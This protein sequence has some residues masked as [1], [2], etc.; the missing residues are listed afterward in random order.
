MPEQ[1]E[2]GGRFQA[3]ST[4][5]GRKNIL[6][7]SA[8]INPLGLSKKVRAA[9]EENID[10]IVH[11]PDVEVTQL[12]EK[13]GEFYGIDKNNI[14]VGNGAVE[15]LYILCR[16]L[17][18]KKVLLTAPTFS[19]YE[20]AAKSVGAQI[21]YF[22]LRERDNFAV[23][24]QDL[25][26]TIKNKNLL[27]LCN[28]NNPTGTLFTLQQLT[29]IIEHAEA[30]GCFVVVDES[31]MDFIGKSEEFSVNQLLK[32]S[33]NLFVLHSL[34]KF[35]ALP[36]LRLGFAA[37]PD[38]EVIRRMYLNKDPWNVN[39]LAQNA[40]A[41]ALADKTYQRRSRSYIKS[42]IDYLCEELSQFAKL[43]IYKPAVNFILINIH[44]TK[45]TSSQFCK[46]MLEENILLRDCSNYPGLSADFIR[47][48]VK[49]REEND[50]LLDALE[51]ILK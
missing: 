39:S 34:T 10:G 11:Y 49:K 12:R 15:L 19:E 50:A 43:K 46:K 20:R 40:G 1:F 35:F 5:S 31:F 17:E 7:F 48:A 27:F 42:E 33:H 51:K 30:N 8:N 22:Y 29:L 2:H 3:V 14:I 47:A 9:I 4:A 6:D 37:C 41:A 28:P 25:I 21:E 16:V 44:D 24:M 38:Q 26:V 23:Q 18:P 13:I 36:G 32:T 45:M